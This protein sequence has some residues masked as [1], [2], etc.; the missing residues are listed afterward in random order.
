MP[1]RRRTGNGNRRATFNSQPSTSN[2]AL[3]LVT[4]TR[5]SVATATVR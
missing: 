4:L 5:T 3:S 2:Y 1:N